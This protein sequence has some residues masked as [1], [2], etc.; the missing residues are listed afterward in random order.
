MYK[1]YSKLTLMN[2]QKEIK[3]LKQEIQLFK[4][5]DISLKYRLLEKEGKDIIRN[6]NRG[7]LE[8]KSS[9]KG[10]TFNN[11]YINLLSLIPTHK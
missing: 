6:K 1:K 2:L 4:E 10:E 9:N 11:N 8:I 5:N 7:E 3:N